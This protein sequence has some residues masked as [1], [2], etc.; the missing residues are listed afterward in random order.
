M[1][2]RDDLMTGGPSI[3]VFM[4]KASEVL[5]MESTSVKQKIQFLALTGF[6]QYI[7]LWTFASIIVAAW[8]GLL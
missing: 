6:A 5:G 7:G 1:M 2:S 4:C 8:A 3:V